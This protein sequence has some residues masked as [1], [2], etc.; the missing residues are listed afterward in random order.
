MSPVNKFFKATKKSRER[1]TMK[2]LSYFMLNEAEN[3]FIIRIT[4]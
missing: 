1:E 3:K 4:L 2:T